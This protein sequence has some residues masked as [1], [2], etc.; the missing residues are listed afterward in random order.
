MSDADFYG[1]DVTQPIEIIA[2]VVDLP[3]ALVKEHSHG[4]NLSRI[5]QDGSWVHDALDDD[6]VE[7]CL[8][9]RLRVDQTLEPVW[10][11][12]RPGEDE[13]TSISAAERARIGFFRIGDYADAHL[14]WSRTSAL[15]ALTESKSDASYAVVEAQRQARQAVAELADTPLHDAAR[16]VQQNSLL[17]GAAPFTDLRPGLDPSLTGSTGSLVLHEGSIPLTSYGLGTRRLTSLAIQEYSNSDHSILAVDELEYGLEPHRLIHLLRFLRSKTESMAMQVFMTTHSPVVVS[18]LGTSE[19][20]VVRSSGGATTAVDVPATLHEDATDVAQGLVRALPSSLLARRVVVGEGATEVGFIR[21]LMN[22]WDS[23]A[24]D[25]LALTAVTLGCAVANGSGDAHA[26]IRARALQ[27][28]GYPCFL[29]VDGDVVANADAIAQA[30]QA[31]VDVLRWPDESSLEDVVVHAL[32]WS[33]VQALVD[34]ALEDVSADA[35]RAK[36]GA[37]LG[38]PPLTSTDVEEWAKEFGQEEVRLS[39]AKAAKGQKV[40]EGSKSEGSAWFKR[41]DRGE[42][43]GKLVYNSMSRIQADTALVSGLER[44]KAFATAPDAVVRESDA[45]ESA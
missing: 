42:R 3:N 35:I 9:V 37:H 7:A 40:K 32:D 41:E 19:I 29:M 33:D 21:Y 5:R 17:L 8:I 39:I 15:A 13:G 6:D 16:M 34:L 20:Q 4:K 30:R 23:E 27:E 36:V 24:D 38:R 14:K 12:I 1:C 22:A 45:N 10:N 18:S 31:G 44:L 28:L 2:A 25:P 26:P 43:L 11:V